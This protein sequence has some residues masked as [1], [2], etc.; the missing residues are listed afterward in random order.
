MAEF[1]YNNKVHTET[2]VPLFEAN[3]GPRMGF[4]LRKKEK[5]EGMAKFVEGMKKVQEEA[6]VALTKAQEDMRRY[7]DRHRVEAVGYKVG[8]L[9]LLRIRDL[10]WQMVRRRSEKL[11]EQFV[12][13]YK[14]KA[15]ISS[16]VVELDLLTTIKIHLVV[17]VSRIK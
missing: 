10:K 3:N 8:D 4:K 15:I 14:I 13:P 17:N 12:G 1:A 6:K 16:N 9:V 5:Y 7:T 2:K 11:T